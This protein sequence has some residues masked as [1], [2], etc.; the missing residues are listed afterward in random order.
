MSDIKVKKQ[1]R[2]EII[3]VTDKGCIF[4]VVFNLII[5]F[6][7]LIWT[8]IIHCSAWFICNIFMLIYPLCSF[9]RCQYCLFFHSFIS[10]WVYT[11]FSLLSPYKWLWM[12]I[13]RI[14]M[15][16]TYRSC[17]F[18]SF[19]MILNIDVFNS[20]YSMVM[21]FHYFQSK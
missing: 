14:C 15:F 11:S 5:C 6:A 4:L 10:W 20:T 9:Q 16:V 17:V 18:N 7:S 12:K 1:K 8:I 3:H 19:L 2:K 13:W 21:S